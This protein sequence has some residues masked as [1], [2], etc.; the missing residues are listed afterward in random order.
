MVKI[1]VQEVARQQGI[2]NIKALAEYV[3]LAYDTAADLWHGRMK[4]MDLATLGKLCKALDCQIEDVLD[5]AK[6]EAGRVQIEQEPFDLGHLLTSSV[7]V[8]LPQARHKGLSVNTEIVP[9]AARWFAGDSHHLRQVLLNL[10]ANAVKFTD[11]GQVTLRVTLIGVVDEQLGPR[12][13]ASHQ[14]LFADLTKRQNS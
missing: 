12:V 3:G 14:E 9:A 13:G 4:R 7:K 11:R 10:L 6:I 2:T 8:V 1:R 5:M